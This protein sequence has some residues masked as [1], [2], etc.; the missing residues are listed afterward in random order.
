MPRCSGAL[1]WACAVIA[2]SGTASVP[3]AHADEGQPTVRPVG[4]GGALGN[5]RLSDEQRVS[6]FAG[7]VSRAPVRASPS[8]GAPRVGR[9]RYLTEDGPFE[10]YP[11]LESRVEP[12]GS[13]WLQIRL[14]MRPN[15]RTG[16]VPPPKPSGSCPERELVPTRGNVVTVRTATLCLL[17]KERTSRG[18]RKV[19][20]VA[21][22]QNVASAYAKRMVRER[23]FAHTS[24]DGDTF[25][26]RIKRTSYLRG[27]LQGW[28]VGENLAWGTGDRATPA[29]IMTAWMRSPAHKRNIVNGRFTEVGLGVA[30]G[31]PLSSAGSGAAAT[32]VNDFGHRRR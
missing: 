11:V 9:L 24:P 31:A 13:T 32:Y 17:N 1:G 5:E 19:K 23:F 28:S 21:P 18:L 30:P 4:V 22:L 16:W 27:E 2:I 7:A 29:E 15:G 10:V 26:A 12:D 14:P 25:L 8:A 6:R 3:G 20:L